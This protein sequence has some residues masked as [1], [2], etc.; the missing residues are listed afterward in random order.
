MAQTSISNLFIGTSLLDGVFVE[1]IERCS[2]D[3]VECYLFVAISHN[4]IVVSLCFISVH[5]HLRAEV[6]AT[7]RIIS[8]LLFR[9][10]I[11]GQRGI[12]GIPIRYQRITILYAAMVPQLTTQRQPHLNTL[13]IVCRDAHYNS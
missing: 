12:A 9:I 7:L 10:V 3:D 1:T 11:A 13:G 2:I 6:Y 8:K 5:P 4:S